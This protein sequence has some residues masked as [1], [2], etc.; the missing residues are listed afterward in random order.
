MQTI[1]TDGLLR[2][3]PEKRGCC[4][5]QTA[6]GKVV[7]FGLG[8]STQ[9]QLCVSDHLVACSKQSECLSIEVLEAAQRGAGDLPL[10]V[11]VVHGSEVILYEAKLVL[12]A[13]PQLD[14]HHMYR[15]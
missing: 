8:F 1:Y 15:M 5:L 13:V 9:H 14:C 7:G 4:F 6:V 10:R 2:N 11:G 3:I 12:G